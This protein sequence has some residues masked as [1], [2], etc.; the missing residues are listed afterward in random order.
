MMMTRRVLRV[1]VEIEGLAFDP[2]DTNP[3]AESQAELEAILTSNLQV[4]SSMDAGDVVTLR[5]TN[6][7]RC[8]K[9]E[10]EDFPGD[11]P[12][13]PHWT[14]LSDLALDVEDEFPVKAFIKQTIDKVALREE[15]KSVQY[16][17]L[18][19]GSGQKGPAQEPKVTY[20]DE[21]AAR[22]FDEGELAY[23][24]EPSSHEHIAKPDPGDPVIPPRPRRGSTI[25]RETPDAQVPPPPGDPRMTR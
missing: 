17:E 10:M 11:E 19:E 12:L 6:G 23:P 25:T 24:G 21:D 18:P 3:Y 15:R 9:V 8:G 5:D 2:D 20:N 13:L 16:S 22:A 4:I 1:L 7:N 14:R